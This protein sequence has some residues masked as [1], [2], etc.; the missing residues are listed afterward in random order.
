MSLTSDYTKKEL[1]KVSDHHKTPASTFFFL[2]FPS[3]PL[4]CAPQLQPHECITIL[5]PKGVH[6]VSHL[7][8][9]SKNHRARANVKANMDFCRNAPGWSAGSASQRCMML[10]YLA[11]ALRSPLLGAVGYTEIA[12]WGRWALV[13]HKMQTIL[14]ISFPIQAHFSHP[15]WT[16]PALLR[17]VQ[18]CPW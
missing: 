16:L 9:V 13:N 7:P 11:Q 12:S 15:S 8:P 5:H 4:A 17:W 14:L 3:A 6:W 1:W 18:R 2:T 10:M